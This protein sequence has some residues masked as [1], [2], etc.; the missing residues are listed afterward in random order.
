MPS[1]FNRDPSL[2]PEYPP[3]S[4]EAIKPEI[5]HLPKKADSWRL[6]PHIVAVRFLG[7]TLF[8]ALVV[9]Y[10]MDPFLYSMHKS[11]AMRAYLFLRNYGDPAV[12]QALADCGIFIP[13]EI[14]TLQ[15]KKGDFSHYYANSAQAERIAWEVIDYMRDLKAMK[16]GNLA[17]ASTVAKIRFHL[18]DQ[19]GFTPPRQWQS[20]NPDVETLTDSLS[21]QPIF[22]KKQNSSS[23]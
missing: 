15:Y 5:A 3:L 16:S 7:T 6:S 21:L 22:T 4:Y 19:W 10:L 12:V 23:P 18:F 11:R 14:A 17:Q 20:L 1:I 2:R 9:L 8:I 13:G